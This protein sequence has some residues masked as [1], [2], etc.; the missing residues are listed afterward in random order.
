MPNTNANAKPNKQMDQSENSAEIHNNTHVWV[1]VCLCMCV[2]VCLLVWAAELSTAWGGTLTFTCSTILRIRN[3]AHFKG[4]SRSVSLTRSQQQQ[5]PEIICCCPTAL[6][7][8]FII[9]WMLNAL[10]I[11]S[12]SLTAHCPYRATYMRIYSHASYVKIYSNILYNLSYNCRVC[13]RVCLCVCVG[14]DYMRCMR[15]SGS[16]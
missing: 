4:N 10:A 5:L 1:Y 16:Q 12:P 7:F 11:I 6:G 8:V 14:W 9:S 3:V 15:V 13:M 2:C